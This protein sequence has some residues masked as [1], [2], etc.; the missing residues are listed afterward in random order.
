MPLRHGGRY[1]A[2]MGSQATGARSSV[3]LI[4]KTCRATLPQ[5]DAPSVE[6]AA[7]IK[8]GIEGTGKAD[9]PRS[10]S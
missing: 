8:A 7:D 2:K 10:S 6:K 3:N 4:E 1:S 5:L 9:Q